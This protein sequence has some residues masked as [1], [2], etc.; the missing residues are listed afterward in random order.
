MKIRKLILTAS[1]AALFAPAAFAATTASKP[2]DCAALQQ[3]FDQQ[4]VTHASAAGASKAK[5][6]R[7]E[8]E[9]LCREGKAADGEKKLH[10][11]LKEL[12]GKAR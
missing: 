10:E 8:G 11:A 6:L 4:V 5:E 2:A 1:A 7:A 12:N 9:K 3:K